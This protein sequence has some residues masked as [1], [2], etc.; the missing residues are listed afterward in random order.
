MDRLAQV[1]KT[2]DEMRH[3]DRFWDEVKHQREML[4]AHLKPTTA[5]EMSFAAGGMDALKSLLT[6]RERLE[7]ERQALESGLAEDTDPDD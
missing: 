7:A 2:L 3:L 6:L 1:I 5:L 4:T